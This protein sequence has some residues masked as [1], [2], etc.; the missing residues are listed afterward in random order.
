MP[1]RIEHHENPAAVRSTNLECIF[2]PAE[3][4]RVWWAWPESEPGFGGTVS[5]AQQC[6]IFAL[7]T[8]AAPGIAIILGQIGTTSHRG[9]GVKVWDRALGEGRF[10][11][12][13]G[14]V[15][16]S[17]DWCYGPR[18]DY[19]AISGRRPD[20]RGNGSGDGVAGGRADAGRG[21]AVRRSVSVFQE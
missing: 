12:G 4:S 21:P 14:W 9:R 6:A 16:P 7:A 17:P 2:I 1:D 19:A 13:F 20:R 10:L 15:S 11:L 5:F 18:H 8:I 3:A